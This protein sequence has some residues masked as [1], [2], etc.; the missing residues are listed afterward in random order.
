MGGCFA[1]VSGI[2]AEHTTWEIHETACKNAEDD[3]V[4]KDDACDI[5]QGEYESVFCTLRP[6]QDRTA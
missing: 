5:L 1:S 4:A 3:R 2:V 6:P